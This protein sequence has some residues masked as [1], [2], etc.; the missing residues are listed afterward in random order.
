MSHLSHLDH[1]EV[2]QYI[3]NLSMQQASDFFSV[4]TKYKGAQWRC[5][6]VDGNWL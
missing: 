4:G 3:A 5:N 2:S 1:L 6:E